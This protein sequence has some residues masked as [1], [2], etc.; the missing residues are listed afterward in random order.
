MN[1]SKI[2]WIDYVVL[3]LI[4]LISILIGLYHGFRG[5]IKSLFQNRVDRQQSFGD[6]ELTSDAFQKEVKSKTS[7]Y[8][9]A[10]ATMGTIPV[11]FSLLASYYSAT[12]LLG[13]PAEIYQYGIEFWLMTIGQFCCPPIGAFITAPFF[14]KHNV[15][16]IF[17]Y[18][19]LRF[20]S[21]L[22]RLVGTYC[23]LIRNS[24]SCNVS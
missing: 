12:S 13:I 18:F 14:A 21:R 22:V 9:T 16:S 11:A 20:G 23:Y 7:E 4:L 3:G 6:F 2:I 19:E 10:N 5:R 8:L 24:I 17:E 1:G 15:S